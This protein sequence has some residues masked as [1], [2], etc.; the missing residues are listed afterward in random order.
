MKYGLVNKGSLQWF[1][2]SSL[3]NCV[4]FHPLQIPKQPGARPFF[5]WLI[6]HWN[7]PRNFG[8]RSNFLTTTVGRN[9]IAPIEVGSSPPMTFTRF[10]H[11]LKWLALGFQPSTAVL[12]LIFFL[13]NSLGRRKKKHKKIQEIQVS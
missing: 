1:M 11:H 12:S 8:S 6:C 10:Q 13:P 5:C 2:K 9:L 3:Y 7:F 4:V